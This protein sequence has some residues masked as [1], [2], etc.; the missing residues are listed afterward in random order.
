MVLPLT[1]SED[2]LIIP[3]SNLYSRLYA[4]LSKCK[5]N[6]SINLWK[7]NRRRPFEA[8]CG[9]CGQIGLQD[10][11]ATQKRMFLNG[12]IVD[13]IKII[14]RETSGLFCGFF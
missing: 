8:F 2:S 5:R 14:R 6:Y 12:E 3:I 4:L 7:C 10:H 11:Y 1:S 9:N 13:N